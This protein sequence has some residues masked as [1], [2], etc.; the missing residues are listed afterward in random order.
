MD[1]D[2]ARSDEGSPFCSVD[3]GLDVLGIEFHDNR[4][5]THSNQELNST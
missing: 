1:C 4:V 3:A 5:L 2:H